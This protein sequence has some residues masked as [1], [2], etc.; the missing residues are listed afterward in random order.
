MIWLG[1]ILGKK[2]PPEDKEAVEAILSGIEISKALSQ[3]SDIAFG[4]LFLGEFYAMRGQKE[5]AKAYLEK[6]MNMFEEMDMNYWLPEA[7]KILAKI[8]N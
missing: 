2:Q 3:H 1:R 8:Q 6:S 4:N 5:M 7:Q